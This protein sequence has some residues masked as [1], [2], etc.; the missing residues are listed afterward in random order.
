MDIREQSIIPAKQI[1]SFKIG[2]SLQELMLS[3]NN[4]YE[5]KELNSYLVVQ[6]SFYKFWILKESNIVVQIGVYKGFGGTFHGIGI[7]STLLD[8]RKKFGS[9]C[10]SLYIYLIPHCEGLCFELEDNDL[11]DEWIQESA[12]IESIYVYDPKII[13]ANIEFVYD[14]ENKKYIDK[15]L[16]IK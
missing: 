15:A 4:D 6:Y 14:L 10:E 2:T 7:G 9:W 3:I 5:T 1:D 16:M 11:D 8:V 13:N 12:P